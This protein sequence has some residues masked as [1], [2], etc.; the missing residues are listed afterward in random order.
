LVAAGA[1]DRS[2][3]LDAQEGYDEKDKTQI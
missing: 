3:V 1:K 2:R